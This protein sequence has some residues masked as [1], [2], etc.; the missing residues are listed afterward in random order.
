[1][2]DTMHTD[3]ARDQMV[4]Q[5]LR[6]WHVLSQPVLDTF[7]RIPR[8]AFVPPAFREVAYADTEIG[9]RILQTVA[10]KPTDR[11]LEIGSGSGFLTACLAA[12]ACSVRSIEIRADLA[13]QA[14][15][16]LRTVGVRNATVE[17][18]DAYAREALGSSEYEVIVLT[19][20]LPARDARFEERLAPGGR[21]FV[22]LGTGTTLHAS[23]G[24]RGADG[25]LQWSVLF[26]TALKP[27]SGAPVPSSFSF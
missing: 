7:A 27:L 19:G 12:H 14:T 9:G 20:S 10:P 8:E 4:Q 24:E 5:Q 21:L 13:Q 3:T 23:L 15:T 11:V 6:A 1:M 18:R 16:N 2:L 17:H 25:T 22:V 26:E